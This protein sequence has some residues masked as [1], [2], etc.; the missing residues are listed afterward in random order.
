MLLDRNGRIKAM[1][2]TLESIAGFT[3]PY[4][5]KK[6]MEVFLSTEIQSACDKVLSGTPEYNFTLTQDIDTVYEVYLVRIPE[7]G[8]LV[9]FHNISERRRLEK[10]RRDFVANVSH[11][12]KTP[13]T[14]V[15]GYVETL[16]SGAFAFPEDARSF[17]QII[18]KSTNQMTHIVNDL[19]QL[20]RLQEKPQFQ[21]LS[22]VNAAEC[23]NAAWDNAFPLA[24]K[25]GITL[26]NRLQ[27][28]LP[29]TSDEQDLIRVFGNLLQNAIRYTPEGSIITV[30]AEDK[31]KEILFGVRDQGPGIGIKHQSRI[32]ERFY[33]ADKERSRLSGGTGLGLAICRNAVTGMGG[34]I[35]VESPPKDAATGSI[36]FFTLPKPG[37]SDN[38]DETQN[39]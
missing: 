25:R 9:V 16:L 6:P 22:T 29:V 5:G 17:L 38:I 28:V 34:R 10:I 4:I 30:F 1:N 3:L 2:P 26:E 33:R 36:F 12:L 39:K 20:T 14:S 8:V 27:K 7:G 21:R 18:L 15:K 23:F 19:L 24:E 11:E 13:L 31:E 35:W 37:N 32:F